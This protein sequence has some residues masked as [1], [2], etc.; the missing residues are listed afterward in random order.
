M[1]GL[2]KFIL[3]SL[4]AR[5]AHALSPLEFNQHIYASYYKSKIPQWPT[6]SQ[7]AALSRAFRRLESQGLIIRVKGRWQLTNW[8]AIVTGHLAGKTIAQ[9]ELKEHPER[10]RP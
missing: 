1:S 2:Q 6:D 4:L 9:H 3:V 8:P 10:Y 7:K 5:E